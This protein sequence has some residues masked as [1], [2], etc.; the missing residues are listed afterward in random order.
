MTLDNIKYTIVAVISAVFAFLDPIANDI[1][2]MLLLFLF[3]AL[4]GI[5][6]DIC[7]GHTWNKKKF[8]WAFVEALIFL[9]F[10]CLIYTIGHF[11]QNMAGALQC[12]SFVSYSL[13]YYY[14]TNICRNMMLILPD[15][16]LGHKTFAFIYSVLSVEIV[17]QVPFLK[18][19]LN[20]E[21]QKQQT[22]DKQL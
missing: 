11:K 10:V 12:V 16:S 13:I 22:Q 17:K 3:N 18:E 14:G 6:A 7:H 20:K 8:Q 9:T 21:E 15:F 2:S 19:Y 5:L 1:F 4:F